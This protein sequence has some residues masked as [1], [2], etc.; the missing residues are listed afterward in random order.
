MKIGVIG[1]INRDTVRLADGTTRTGWGGMLYNLVTLNYLVRK[2]D[3]IIPACNA[4]RDCYKQIE[5]II[6]GLPQIYSEFIYEVPEKNNHCFLAYHDNENKSEVLKGGVR[7]LKFDEI[8]PLLKCDLVLVNY[9]S[10]RD[11]YLRSLRKF[12]RYFKGSIYMDI[13]SLTLGKRSNGSRYLCI[14][15]YWRETVALADY[16]QMNR[17]ELGLLTESDMHDDVN[18]NRLSRQ[19]INNLTRSRPNIKEKVLIMTDGINGCFLRYRRS[20]R[21]VFEHVPPYRR[22][23]KGDTTGCGDC[24]SAGFIA[25]LVRRKS[26]R[27]CTVTGN[28]AAYERI[29][30][31]RGHYRILSSDSKL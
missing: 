1:T 5:T 13:H 21:S 16:I 9:I 7:P 8:E 12:R 2:G 3:I 23:L 6:A 18:V 19:F 22:A 29:V 27:D 24:F 25:G 26:L 15:R 4:G 17:Q 20:G 10:G 28:R 31:R 30:D 14:P 11:V